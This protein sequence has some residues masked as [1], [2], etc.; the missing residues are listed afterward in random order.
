VHRVFNRRDVMRTATALGAALAIPGA[1]ACEAFAT[2]LRVTHPWT[3]ASRANAT[4]AAINLLID[5]V[6]RDDRLIGVTSPVAAGAELVGRDIG[7][8]LDLRIP[9]GQEIELDEA[10]THIRLVGLNQPLLIGRS[11]PLQLDFVQGG[12]V[13]MFL[14]VD[15]LPL[16]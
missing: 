7:P 15:Q 6:S 12:I 5:Q 3:R 9:Q 4:T 8:A 13:R 11:Y 2:T 10:R 1:R 14:S 16:R